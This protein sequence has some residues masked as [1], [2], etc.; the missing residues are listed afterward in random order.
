MEE[1]E[2]KKGLS[3]CSKNRRA[4]PDNIIN[5]LVTGM[6]YIY[7]RKYDSA[8]EVFDEISEDDPKNERVRYW[9]GLALQRSGKLDEAK[10][11][12][13]AYLKGEHLEDYQKS[14]TN[15]RLGQVASRQKDYDGAIE[16]YK[17]AVKIDGHKGSKRAL[18][19]LKERKKEGKI[20]Y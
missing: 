17:E 3:S 2:L 16:H 14:Y 19:R 12:F 11:E 20:D 1:G 7:M 15:Y 4:Y 10:A 8:L 13:T 18:D 9:R 6:V 5:N